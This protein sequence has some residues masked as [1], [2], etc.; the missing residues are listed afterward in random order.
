MLNFNLFYELGIQPKGSI[1][2][3]KVVCP[4]CAKVG[5]TN[6]KDTCLSINLKDGLY[7]CHKCGWSGCV[8][9]GETRNYSLPVKSNF[10]KL[11]DE[12]LSLFTGRGITQEVVIANKIAQEGDWVI[13]PYLRDKVLVNVKKRSIKDKDFRQGK[14]C[15][16]II[17]N[18]DR[19]KGKK[20]IIICEGEFDC[21]A[22]EV[23]GY[24]NVTSV[25][26]GAPNEQ[27]KNVEKKL[28]CITNCYEIFEEAELIYIAVDKDANGIRLE[29]ELIRRFGAEKCKIVGFPS[30]R[31][32]AN[33]VLIH[34]GKQVLIDCLNNAKDVKVTGVFTIDDVKDSML[35]TFDNGKKRGTT[36]HF[37]EFNPIWT[38]RTGEVTLWTGYMNE[39]KSTFLKQ[40][41][42]LK[43]TFDGEKTAVFS[44]EEFPADEFYDDLIHSYI[45]KAT[46]SYYRNVMNKSEYLKGIEFVK[47]HFFYVYPEE[48]FTWESV[49]KKMI[50]LIRKKGIRNVVLDPYNQFDHTQGNM[51]IDQ[52]VSKFMGRLKRFALTYDVSIHLVA[53][54]VTPVF[55]GGQD[56]PKPNA[57]KIKGGGTFADKADNVGYV[58][59]PFRYSR[60]GDRTVLVGFDKVKKKRLVG[61]G[62][63]AE[64]IFNV[65]TNRYELNGITPFDIERDVQSS[66]SANTEFIKE[67]PKPI[68]SPKE[69]I[70]T[71]KEDWD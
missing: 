60:K 47:K 35:N 70:G 5:K 61:E 27:D 43:A 42:L 62:G 19:V 22:F 34:D 65:G 51:Q 7:N 16:A 33:E 69:S 2:Q 3:Q 64:F 46:D 55:I 49:S 50:Y 6:L 56:Y 24:T 9:A 52:Y 37:K 25:N 18:Y 8:K 31:K 28:E 48:D 29:G 54:Q 10:T 59:I 39:G 67:E 57:Y 63:E 30:D 11:S 17:Y 26:Q 1:Q 15:E 40:I 12:A 14:D 21:M 44:P 4:N 38:H 13:F 32:D 68:S 41:L 66:L 71:Y 36:T 58:W 45:G 23:A 20:E 53:H